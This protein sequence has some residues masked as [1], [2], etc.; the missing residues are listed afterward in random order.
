[1]IEIT[2]QGSRD[3]LQRDLNLNPSEL[4][5]IQE[6][7]DIDGTDW[8]LINLSNTSYEKDYIKGLWIEAAIIISLVSFAL[9]ILSFFLLKIVN[10][11]R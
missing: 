6:Y 11:R 2:S 10:K 9:L 1:M 4:A 7:K 8:R 5:S 3:K